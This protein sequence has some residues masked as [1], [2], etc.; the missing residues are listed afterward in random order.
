MISSSSHPLDLGLD[1]M[2]LV[3]GLLHEH[4]A[5]AA[6][7]QMLRSHTGWILRRVHDWISR[8]DPRTAQDFWSHIGAGSHLP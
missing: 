1:T 2:I 3:Y 7:E 4:P 8:S 6:C 5:R